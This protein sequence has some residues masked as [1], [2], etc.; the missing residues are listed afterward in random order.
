MLGFMR[1]GWDKTR[2]HTILVCFFPLVFLNKESIFVLSNRYNCYSLIYSFGYSNAKS[3]S[4]VPSDLDWQPMNLATDSPI[5]IYS[6]DYLM[7][8]AIDYWLRRARQSVGLVPRWRVA[9][10]SM[11]PTF[12]S[13]PVATPSP[14]K[15]TWAEETQFFLANLTIFLKIKT[16]CIEGDHLLGDYISHF[17]IAVLHCMLVVWV[18]ATD[19][20]AITV[21]NPMCSKCV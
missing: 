13:A 12:S 16:K 21:T 3:L 7:H 5:R 17:N 4:S 1:C 11:P 19:I 14:S 20:T 2:T 6:V 18:S 9:C 15:S 10:D 8:L